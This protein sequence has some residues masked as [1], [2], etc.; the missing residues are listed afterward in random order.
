LCPAL[1]ADLSRRAARLRAPGNTQ[2]K[3]GASVIAIDEEKN[4][5]MLID[6]LY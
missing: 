1:Q 3:R 6:Y 4:K 2:T 5:E